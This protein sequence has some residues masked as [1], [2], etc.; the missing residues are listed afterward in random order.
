VSFL[1]REAPLAM[2]GQLPDGG[3][4]VLAALLDE[5]QVPFLGARAAGP[6][7]SPQRYVFYVEPG[8]VQEAAALACFAARQRAGARIVIVHPAD[9][10]G[11]ARARFVAERA[12]RAGAGEVAIR[13]QVAGSEA[14]PL[15]PDAAVV[16]DLGPPERTAGVLAAAAHAPA[17]DFVLLPGETAAAIARDPARFLRPADQARFAGR[18]F[19]IVSEST[20]PPSDAALGAV[21]AAGRIL[22]EALKRSGRTTGREVLV[23]T[24]A[25]LRDFATGLGPI[26]S[27]G[28]ERRIGVAGEILGTIDPVTGVTQRRDGPDAWQRIE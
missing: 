6:P 14:E 4:E 2:V 26:V 9:A 24:L 22:V 27:F 18:L 19:T 23:D 8:F 1:A 28:P 12:R 13:A 7:R 15:P 17:L 20:P 5:R 25:G 21:G 10:A 16:V 11:E 3:G